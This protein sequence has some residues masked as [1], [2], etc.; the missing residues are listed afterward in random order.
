MDY[1]QLISEFIVLVHRQNYWKFFYVASVPKDIYTHTHTDTQ[2][3]IF[4]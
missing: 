4:I 1:V 3:V 2:I